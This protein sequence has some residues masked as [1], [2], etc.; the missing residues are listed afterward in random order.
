MGRITMTKTLADMT[1][2][3]RANCVGMWC[4]VAGQLEILAEPDGMVDYHDTAILHSVKRNGGE[5]VLA[6]NVTPRFDLPR[7]WNP[8]GTPSAGDWEQA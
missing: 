5:Y 3:Q 4:E 2:E 8:D 6:K 1:P 7:A